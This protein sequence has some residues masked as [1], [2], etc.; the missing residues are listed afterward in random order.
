MLPIL[1]IIGL[2]IAVYAMCR[3]AQVTFE[4]SE[5]SN[6]WK[7]MPYIARFSVVMSVSVVGLAAIGMLTL[8]LL[9]SGVDNGRLPI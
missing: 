9:F 8:M 3:L 5:G 1:K 2:I 7:G 4:L 6:Y